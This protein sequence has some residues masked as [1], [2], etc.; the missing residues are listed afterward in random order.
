MVSRLFHRPLALVLVLALTLSPQV[1]VHAAMTMQSGHG[2]T[3][4]MPMILSDI[5]HG[6]TG[7]GSTA[8]PS[9]CLVRSCSGVVAV[10]PAPILQIIPALGA[11]YVAT[12]F[13]GEHGITIAPDPAPPRLTHLV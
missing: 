4:G 7:K 10:L 13:Q 6:C 12:V 11:P 2:L 3:A 1:M 8:I 5:C 9:D